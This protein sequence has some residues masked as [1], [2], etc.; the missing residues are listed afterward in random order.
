MVLLTIHS[1]LK[2][3]GDVRSSSVEEAL[4]ILLV[5]GASVSCRDSSGETP[6]L[7][8]RNLL[9]DG[10]YQRA[11]QIA[12]ILISAGALV[13]ETNNEVRRVIDINK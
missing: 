1:Y 10:L 13:D 8:V 3:S 11:S 4:R 5:N 6:L 9:R 2:S 12:T 7:Y